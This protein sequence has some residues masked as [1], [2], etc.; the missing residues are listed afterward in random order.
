M[1][2][3]ASTFTKSKW[4]A[5]FAELSS[6]VTHHS[7]MI[8]LEGVDLLRR[9]LITRLSFAAILE[10]GHLFEHVCDTF[11][12]Y[13][14]ASVAGPSGPRDA[15][16]IISL[17][18]LLDAMTALTLAMNVEKDEYI[19]LLIRARSPSLLK[20]L[21]TAHSGPLRLPVSGHATTLMLSLLAGIDLR[22]RGSALSLPHGSNLARHVRSLEEKGALAD[23]MLQQLSHDIDVALIRA[24]HDFQRRALSRLK[25]AVD[26]HPCAEECYDAAK[27]TFEAF[28]SAKCHA[29][30]FRGLDHLW[31]ALIDHPDVLCT[32]ITDSD[33]ESLKIYATTKPRTSSDT[34]LFRAV[35]QLLA[36]MSKVA[37]KSGAL[38]AFLVECATRRSYMLLSCS[39][40]NATTS[41]SVDLSVLLFT[42]AI[43]SSVTV[44]S[45]IVL[46]WLPRIHASTVAI[47]HCA[48]ETCRSTLIDAPSSVDGTLPDELYLGC[49]LQSVRTEVAA[50]AA[51]AMRLLAD[52]ISSHLTLL[53]NEALP[54]LIGIAQ[55]VCQLC[56]RI[57]IQNPTVS[58]LH[59]PMSLLH[60][61]PR[62]IRSLRPTPIG[63]AAAFLLDVITSASARCFEC[64]PV[65]TLLSAM[66]NLTRALNKSALV[67]LRS[68]P[69]RL[70]SHVCTSTSTF[71]SINR[72]LPTFTVNA[73]AQLT[74]RHCEASQGE[75][76]ATA[77][78]LS[79]ALSCA[80][81]ER[82]E[83]P[84]DVMS[85]KAE[86]PRNL[87]MAIQRQ[88]GVNAV[89][90]SFL[91]LL[92]AVADFQLM[93][94]TTDSMSSFARVV[95]VP[96]LAPEGKASLITWTELMSRH[97][98]VLQRNMAE[99]D[100]R[101][102]C[103][104]DDASARA[105][106]ELEQFTTIFASCAAL[107]TC[108]ALLLDRF[109]DL[110]GYLMQTAVVEYAQ[111]CLAAASPTMILD[112][113]DERFG[114]L[115]PAHY[116]LHRAF[117]ECVACAGR[118]LRL[119]FEKSAALVFA[120]IDSDFFKYACE[121]ISCDELDIRSKTALVAGL[122]TL[123]GLTRQVDLSLSIEP[124]SDQLF[125]ASRFAG[126]DV[127]TLAFRALL[128]FQFKRANH[129][130][131]ECGWTSQIAK[132]LGPTAALVHATADH[133]DP[134]LTE[135]SKSLSYAVSAA[136]CLEAYPFGKSDVNALSAALLRVA[137]VPRAQIL[138]VEAA[139]RLAGS[140]E[141][142][143]VLAHEAQGVGLKPTAEH[144]SPYSKL[145][146]LTFFA[147]SPAGIVSAGTDAI[148]MACLHG[149]D[150]FAA[151]IVRMRVI[152]TLDGT[153]REAERKNVMPPLPTL[154]LIAALSSC[155]SLQMQLAKR[156]EFITEISE[157][158]IV[159]DPAGTLALMTLRNL[160]FCAALKNQLCLDSRV[161]RIFKNALFLLE[162]GEPE[163]R[164]RKVDKHA[165]DAMERFRRQELAGSALWSLVYGNQR[166]KSYI[167]G[168]MR[169]GS[170][171]RLEQLSEQ[172]RSIEH[173]TALP[174]YRE[175]MDRIVSGL[176]NCG[177]GS[178]A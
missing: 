88:E 138:F 42:Q 91:Q 39:S 149:G 78:W 121:K 24:E 71:R 74:S 157:L 106:F 47:V 81:A 176:I 60:Y 49:A 155:P 120:R 158:A 99:S 142:R 95:A 173:H 113:L 97:V 153:L 59:G 154:R 61:T 76:A 159:A 125:L 128:V 54:Q 44:P 96:A 15:E 147:N 56:L 140:F 84:I 143:N 139:R 119:Y 66:P 17:L 9:L 174:N 172:V 164:R 165:L 3:P 94:S 7:P 22:A 127:T 110:H 18:H 89:S 40:D 34:A 57:I 170:G 137:S 75:L 32:A 35:L 168:V 43:L 38:T 98:A 31:Y 19:S 122:H 107:S 146:H 63:E 48:S 11:K 90:A 36:N 27:I 101:V 1:P 134:S 115:L 93:V 167:R 41:N 46:E 80:L 64:L 87:L 141:G 161:L 51:V 30:C 85:N 45:D 131:Y 70:L 136:A 2:L 111:A 29:D 14:Q 53:L 92:A 37:S 135:F 16:V 50:T 77:C 12:S 28:K 151:P 20:A 169:E 152:D 79:N 8:V 105:R 117:N 82:G 62:C 114:V 133:D 163:G 65:P 123:A 145:I 162:E 58:S 129:A 130:A 73:V 109:P 25:L 100:E 126:D 33:V 103:T 102:I 86:L 156:P 148:A 69:S 83:C 10:E 175:R 150:D 68:L 4:L 116:G 52:V 67:H 5:F 124:V 104:A 55:A 21:W 171:V 166:A 26:G 112:A 23:S 108:L 144:R 178:S 160:S 6:K 72:D 118:L 13:V 132:S 177:L